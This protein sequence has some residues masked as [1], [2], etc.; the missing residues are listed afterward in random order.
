MKKSKS[1]EAEFA[2]YVAPSMLGLAGNSCYILADTYFISLGMGSLGL[3]SLNIALPFF[4]VVF[5]LG[6]MVGVG[7]GTRYALRQDEN[8]F[9]Q[10]LWLDFF[11]S[12]PFLLLDLAPQ[13]LAALLGAEGEVLQ[14]TSEY[15]WVVLLFA[16]FFMLNYNVQAFVRNDGSPQL[17]MMGTLLGSLFNIVF[18]YIFIFPMGVGMFGAAL[19][20]GCSP[21][22]SLATLSTHF[23]RRKNNFHVKKI[24]LKKSAAADIMHLGSASFVTEVANGVVIFSF[25]AILLRLAGNIAVAAYGVTSNIALVVAALFSGISQGMQPL[26]SREC[27][28]GNTQNVRKLLKVGL[29]SGLCL[30][31]VMYLCLFAGTDGVIAVF[32]SEHSAELAAIAKPGVRLYFLYLFAGGANIVLSAYYS[33]VGQAG[34]GFAIAILRGLVLIVPM[35]F[36]LS[37]FF[38]ITGLWLSLAVTDVLVLLF[39]VLTRKKTK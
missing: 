5:G 10:A 37:H 18:D 6:A 7:A 2:R 22:V 19:A 36:V 16:P 3:A 30:A 34:K 38:G 35:A 33:A 17:V 23:L 15:L 28:Q 21:I 13:K 4:N 27:G 11:F 32:N 8:A 12:I 25:N 1:I 14:V 9:T 29:F 39:A 24:F 31:G 26:L 20:T